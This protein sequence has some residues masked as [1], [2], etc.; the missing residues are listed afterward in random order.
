LAKAHVIVYSKPGCHLCEEAKAAITASGC[1]DKFELTEINIEGDSSLLER[2]QYD[3]PVISINGVD[4]FK[5]R[6]NPAEFRE[7]IERISTD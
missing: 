2:Y 7:V 5:H 4:T 6:L 1:S 3:I